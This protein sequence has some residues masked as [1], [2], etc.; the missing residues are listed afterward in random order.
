MPNVLII[1]D[2]PDMQALERMALECGGYDVTA[3]SNGAEGLQQLRGTAEPP[4]AILLD[5]MMPVMDGLTFLA[6]R[7]RDGI[8]ADVPVICI[9][10]AGEELMAEARQLGAVACMEKPTNLDELCAMV[11]RY[12]N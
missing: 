1:E 5:L 4:C 7:E 10:A 6:T 3:A 11:G 9:T 12:C 2:D 8:G